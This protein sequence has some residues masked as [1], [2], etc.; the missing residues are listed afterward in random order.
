M[1]EPMNQ[2]DFSVVH[3]VLKRWLAQIIE[4][5]V[6]GQFADL[7]LYASAEVS[8]C[9]HSS[10]TGLLESAEPLAWAERKEETKLRILLKFIEFQGVVFFSSPVAQ[11]LISELL[12]IFL[13]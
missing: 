9:W 12:A 2:S 3:W 4:F 6:S 13:P 5:Q 10:G 8:L 11:S 1:G 7:A